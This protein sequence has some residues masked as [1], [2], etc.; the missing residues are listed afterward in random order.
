MIGSML[1][2]ASLA[3]RPNGAPLAGVA[4]ASLACGEVVAAAG[5]GESPRFRL[6]GNLR[7]GHREAPQSPAGLVEG[8]MA[9]LRDAPALLNVFA[10]G[11]EPG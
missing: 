6:V 7:A 10:N 11:F 8:C 4:L 2:A 5:R 1:L 9:P 3:T